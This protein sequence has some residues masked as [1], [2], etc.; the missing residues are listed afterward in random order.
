MN[1]NEIQPM[2]IPNK[3]VGDHHL[4]KYSISGVDR[5]LGHWGQMRYDYL[6]EY[7]PVYFS[8]LVLSG[9][10][11]LELVELDQ[12]AQERYELIIKHKA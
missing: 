6:K 12:Q 8:Q 4:C 10:F 1:N 2:E 3:K 7:R 11:Y 9:R 5:P